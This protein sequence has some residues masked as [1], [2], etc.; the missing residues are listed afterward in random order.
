VWRVGSAV[1]QVASPRKPCVKIA[2]YWGRSDLLRRVFET[3]RSGWYLRVLAEG[4]VEVGGAVELLDR[5]HPA[6]T[7][8]RAGGVAS[9]RRSDHAAARELAMVASLPQRWKAWLLS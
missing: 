5:P 9:A 3:G 6:W 7:V 8:A 1:L 2:R 4:V